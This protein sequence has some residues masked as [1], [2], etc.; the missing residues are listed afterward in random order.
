MSTP[1]VVSLKWLLVAWPLSVFGALYALVNLWAY[2]G[3]PLSARRLSTSNLQIEGPGKSRLFVTG[4]LGTGTGIYASLTDES[5]GHIA[6]LDERNP[7]DPSLTLNGAVPGSSVRIGFDP[8]TG[9]PVITLSCVDEVTGKLGP[10]L[11]VT[12]DE[13]GRG[14]VTG[15]P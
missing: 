11:T 15:L 14:Q 13:Q 1:R 6:T 4:E 3:L 10:G 9:R 8:K 2:S 5:G 7:G 12:L